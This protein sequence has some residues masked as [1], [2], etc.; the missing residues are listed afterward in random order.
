MYQVRLFYRILL[1]IVLTRVHADSILG[2]LSS[3]IFGE[4]Q[5]VDV[6]EVLGKMPASNQSLRRCNFDS[7]HGEGRGGNYKHE[8]LRGIRRR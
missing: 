5:V 8:I 6:V 3:A 4:L 2:G 1:A 7:H